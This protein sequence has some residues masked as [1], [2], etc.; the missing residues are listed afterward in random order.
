[1]MVNSSHQRQAGYYQGEQAVIHLTVDIIS[2]AEIVTKMQQYM[3]NCWICM[4]CPVDS[5]TPKLTVGM[6]DR[7]FWALW[8]VTSKYLRC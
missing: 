7:R 8:R 1:M 5:L 2:N 3:L 6:T 4:I